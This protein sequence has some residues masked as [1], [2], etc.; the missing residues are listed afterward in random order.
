MVSLSRRLFHKNRRKQESIFSP[1]KLVIP[2][3]PLMTARSDT[4]C[5]R[6]Q[7]FVRSK[8]NSEATHEGHYRSARRQ[9]DCDSDRKVDFNTE[10]ANLTVIRA[11]AHLLTSK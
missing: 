4:L 8:E 10:K 11:N 5:A 1:F 3:E 7:I 9:I 6:E 2:Q